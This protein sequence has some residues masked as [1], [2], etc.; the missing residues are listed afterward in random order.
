MLFSMSRKVAALLH[1]PQELVGDLT[2]DLIPTASAGY[3]PVK[4]DVT[5]EVTGHLGSSGALIPIKDLQDITQSALQEVDAL[6][7]SF[8]S[9]T[10]QLWERI[11]AKLKARDAGPHSPDLQLSRLELTFENGTQFTQSRHQS[12]LTMRYPFVFQHSVE[13]DL[14][15]NGERLH[16]GHSAEAELTLQ[17]EADEAMRFLAHEKPRLDATMEAT[18][19][20]ITRAIAES[21]RHSEFKQKILKVSLKE[22]AKNQ[23]TASVDKPQS[24]AHK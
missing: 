3:H 7:P 11:E 12:S 2:S 15:A 20:M 21:L 14:G 1:F 8:A 5:V 18:G 22:T 19:E 17:V 6:Q 9:L 16:H 24:S 13:F 10:S 23:F 4:F